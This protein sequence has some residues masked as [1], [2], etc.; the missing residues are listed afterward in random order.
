M[1][2]RGYN[3]FVK[4]MSY[5]FSRFLHKVIVAGLTF[6]DTSQAILCEAGVDVDANPPEQHSSAAAVDP[7]LF[8]DD[9]HSQEAENTPVSH[10][11]LPDYPCKNSN[12]ERNSGYCEAKIQRLPEQNVATDNRVVSNDNYCP[13]QN[14]TIS[15][16]QQNFESGKEVG[17]NLDNFANGSWGSKFSNRS[18]AEQ[19]ILHSTL[20]TGAQ[21]QQL[22]PDQ[23]YKPSAEPVLSSDYNQLQDNSYQNQKYQQDTCAD[24]TVCPAAYHQ[25]MQAQEY[26]STYNEQNLINATQEP[27]CPAEISPSHASNHI[28]LQQPVDTAQQTMMSPSDGYQQAV[29]HPNNNFPPCSLSFNQQAATDQCLSVGPSNLPCKM[30]AG[31]LQHHQGHG[32]HG[33]GDIGSSSGYETQSNNSASPYTSPDSIASI[34]PSASD[35]TTCT[36]ISR[37]QMD[38][39]FQSSQVQS[40]LCH[41]DRGPVA[42]PL[43]ASDHHPTGLYPTPG[44]NSGN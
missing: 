35:V 22:V 28:S 41:G 11:V 2:L 20:P 39:Q 32:Y 37:S 23:T 16:N 6:G 7:N 18:N 44:N 3:C 15:F 36:T 31:T 33:N 25:K 40:S 27:P 24:P 10:P 17:E 21:P 1:L 13:V 8:A 34:Q 14:N 12:L 29:V 9:K 38:G 19:S 43:S 4:P 30:S 26:S 42:A 5:R